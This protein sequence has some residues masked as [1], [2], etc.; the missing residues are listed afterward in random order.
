MPHLI[1]NPSKHNSVRSYLLFT[2]IEVAKGMA[3]HVNTEVAGSGVSVSGSTW[4]SHVELVVSARQRVFLE[5]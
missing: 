3:H 2:L 1:E 4:A 5:H